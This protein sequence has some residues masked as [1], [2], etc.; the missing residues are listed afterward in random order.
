L[1]AGLLAQYTAGPLTI[2]Y[3]VFLVASCSP[4]A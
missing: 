3:V 2:P 1:I 4:Q